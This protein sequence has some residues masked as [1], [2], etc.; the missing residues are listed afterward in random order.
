MVTGSGLA[1]PEPLQNEDSCSWFKQYE[2]CATTNGWETANKLQCLPTLLRGHAWAIY[3]SL[4]EDV[5]D[6]YDY[7]KMVLLGCLSP[8]TN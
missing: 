6:T 2:V 8:E 3:N 5:T 1:L 4:L 7:L